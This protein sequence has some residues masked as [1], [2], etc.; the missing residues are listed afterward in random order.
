MA[1][2]RP[3]GAMIL[4]MASTLTVLGA[5]YAWHEYRAARLAW[6]LACDLAGGQAPYVRDV[7]R[8]ELH[9]GW[10]EQALR[11][12]RTAP[13]AAYGPAPGAG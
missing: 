9:E 3:A 11:A 6:S 7:V 5:L 10:A 1:A 2:Q 12:I 8:F 4:G 13:A